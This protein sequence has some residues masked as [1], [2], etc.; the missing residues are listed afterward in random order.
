MLKTKNTQT[1]NVILWI[2]FTCA[3]FDQRHVKY[4]GRHM[5]TN[6]THSLIFCVNKSI[7]VWYIMFFIIYFKSREQYW[8]WQNEQ[9]K[10]KK[11]T[12]LI[13]KSHNCKCSWLCYRHMSVF[14]CVCQFTLC[15]LC[16]FYLSSVSV[17]ICISMPCY[18]PPF[19]VSNHNFFFRF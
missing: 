19:F 17:F 14:R 4:S 11:E 1:N 13:V 5:H 15:W 7:S 3:A 12:T 10:K 8:L 9:K 18:N 16:F 2:L 6:M